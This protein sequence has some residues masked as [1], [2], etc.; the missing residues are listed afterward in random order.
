MPPS[1]SFVGDSSSAC[2]PRK[3][4]SCLPQLRRSPAPDAPE[5]LAAW[6]ARTAERK[7]CWKSEWNNLFF[8]AL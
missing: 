3:G 5:S 8:K 4:A 2:H 6:L 1:H 7:L